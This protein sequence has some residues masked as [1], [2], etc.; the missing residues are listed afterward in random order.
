MPDREQFKTTEEYN[1][2]FQNYRAKHKRKLKIYNRE[3]MS[4]WR[5]FKKYKVIG[6]AL[7]IERLKKL[8]KRLK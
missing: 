6:K 5:K 1:L 4:L 8:N 2:W 3:Y 7:F